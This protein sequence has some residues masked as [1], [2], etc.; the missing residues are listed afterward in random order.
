MGGWERKLG[1]RLA[2]LISSVCES[3]G[4]GGGGEEGIRGGGVKSS[5]SRRRTRI[6]AAAAAACMS[7]RT[8]GCSRPV[9]GVFFEDGGI[10]FG[11][12]GVVDPQ[13]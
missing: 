7:R 5:L 1:T 12:T 9:Q 11:S 6:D 8:H 13:W 10:A 2:T 3:A 4:I